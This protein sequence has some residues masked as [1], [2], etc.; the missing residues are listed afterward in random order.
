[1]VWEEDTVRTWEK[2]DQWTD[3][4]ENIQYHLPSGGVTLMGG[5]GDFD[6]F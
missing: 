4:W 5:R 1:M 6:G 2:T 3:R